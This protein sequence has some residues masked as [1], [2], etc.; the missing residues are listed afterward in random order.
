MNANA[1]LAELNRL[2]ETLDAG[3]ENK[4]GSS[5]GSKPATGAGIASRTGVRDAITDVLDSPERT[6]SVVSLRE[7]PEVEAFRDDLIGGMIRVDTANQLLRLVNAVLS[8]LLV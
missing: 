7:A 5:P 3:L 6:T 1:V 4:A 2:V 8:K